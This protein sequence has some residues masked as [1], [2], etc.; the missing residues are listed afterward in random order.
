MAD[1][2]PHVPAEGAPIT[3]DARG[4]LVVPDRPIV[5]FIEGD[6]TGPD[7]W[8]ASRRVLD[9][10][11]ERAYGGTRALAWMEVYAGDKA[12]EVHGEPVWLPA[13]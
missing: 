3:L 8:A 1:P 11:V 2:T 7:I 10:A 5:C 4:G 12:N 13:A 9:A 6:G